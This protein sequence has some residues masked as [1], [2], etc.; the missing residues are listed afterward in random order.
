M[1]V[2]NV[3]EVYQFLWILVIILFISGPVRFDIYFLLRS[4]V[5]TPHSGAHL[6]V[7]FCDT[8]IMLKKKKINFNI[9]LNQILQLEF[10][11]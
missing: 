7:L 4:M 3:K 8:N 5:S 9:I 11:C 6:V 2:N 10:Y 1:I